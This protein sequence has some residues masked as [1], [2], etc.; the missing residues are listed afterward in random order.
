MDKEYKFKRTVTYN[1]YM[2]YI[3][4]DENN[5]SY[6]E[7]EEFIKH[8]DDK[9]VATYGFDNPNI[10]NADCMEL[11]NSPEFVKKSDEEIDKMSFSYLARKKL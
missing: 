1:N 11:D 7:L 10:N 5:W 4:S 2:D 8:K 9:V 3:N 6:V